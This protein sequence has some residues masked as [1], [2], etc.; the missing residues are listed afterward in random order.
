MRRRH[1]FRQ[2]L[3]AAAALL[4]AG[5]GAGAAVADVPAQFR[6]TVACMIRAIRSEPHISRVRAGMSDARFSI[7][8]SPVP[9]PYVEYRTIGRDGYRGTIRFVASVYD[10]KLSF[11][12]GLNGLS[13]VGGPRP[14]DWGTPRVMDLWKTRCGVGAAAVYN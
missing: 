10:G 5:N 13:V 2:S 11:S 6:P 14:D 3:G 1:A 9:H 12:T 7:G 4:L 8:E